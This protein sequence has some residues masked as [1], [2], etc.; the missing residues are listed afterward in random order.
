MAVAEKEV[1]SALSAADLLARAA[2]AGLS[3]RPDGTRLHIRGPG[4]ARALGEALLE[5]KAEVLALLAAST[6]PACGKGLDAKGCCW[7]RTC[8]WRRCKG[9]GRNSGSGF[10]RYC[11]L[12]EHAGLADRDPEP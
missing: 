4:S 3:V 8:G 7:A 6:C 1:L 12:C 10:L 2:A 11:L 9:C 5:R